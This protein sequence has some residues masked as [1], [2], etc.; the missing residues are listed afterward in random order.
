MDRDIA[1]LTGAF[2]NAFL[3]ESAKNGI[4]IIVTKTKFRTII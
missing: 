1:K 2:L 4:Q 3:W